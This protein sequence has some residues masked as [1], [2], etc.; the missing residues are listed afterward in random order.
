MVRIMGMRSQ[1]VLMVLL[2]EVHNECSQALLPSLCGI[3]VYKDESTSVTTKELVRKLPMVSSLRRKSL[4][5]LIKDGS[6][7]IKG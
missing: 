2:D 5:S 1:S 7:L 3:L 6:L 4:A